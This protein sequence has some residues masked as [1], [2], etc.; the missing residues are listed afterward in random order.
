MSEY[1]SPGKKSWFTKLAKQ[2]AAKN[3]TS[4]TLLTEGINAIPM[5][6]ITTS[7][8]QAKNVPLN[9]YYYNKDLDIY[10]THIKSNPEPL[11]VTGEKHRWMH[12]A[13]S[14]WSGK[15]AT[16][17]EICAKYDF[18]QELFLEYKTVHG[19][20]HSQDIFTKE[21]ILD[22]PVEILVAQAIQHKSKEWQS[23]Y[24]K[25]VSKEQKDNAEKWIKYERSTL[26]YIQEVLKNHKPYNVPRVDLAVADEPFALVLP[27][28]D[29]HFGKSSSVEQT[30]QSYS[31]QRCR[32]LLHTHT[33]NILS[34][35]VKFGR[36]EKIVSVVGSDWNHTDNAFGGTTKGTPQDLDGT[37]GIILKESLELAVEHVDMLRQVAPVELVLSSGNHDEYTSIALLMYLYAWYR[38]CSDV[39]VHLSLR[40]RNYISYGNNLLAFSHGDET[41]LADICRIIPH[42][43][44][45]IWATVDNAALFTGHKHYEYSSNDSGIEVFQSS[46]LSAADLWHAKKGYVLSRQSL[47]G[48]II[49]EDE[50]PG[51]QIRSSVSNVEK[52]GFDK[53]FRG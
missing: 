46:S 42:E 19:W 8:P 23:E 52:F 17:A 9:K 13:Y 21:E 20:S 47:T 35:I 49:Y 26:R 27:V 48:Y 40:P 45:D 32:E 30:G 24:D 39:T 43:A 3:S 5:P 11:F 4:N 16:A 29:L 25:K 37:P 12:K 44:K 36:P 7:F 41:K 38:D 28:Q 6:V 31:R 50:G 53:S 51:G 33:N 18:P 2:E 15:E 1:I 22:Q 14:D 34:R 10:V